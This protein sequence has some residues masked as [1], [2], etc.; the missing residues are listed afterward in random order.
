MPGS[1]RLVAS[2]ALVALGVVIAGGCSSS[3]DE[4]PPLGAPSS[5]AGAGGASAGS[6]GA[7]GGT[8]GTGGTG[9]V[10]SVGV[11]GGS[12]GTS[13]NAGG[14]SG[15]DCGGD[16]YEAM[17]LP[18]DLYVMLD[19]SDSMLEEAG[20]ATKWEAIQ[21]ALTA[22]VADPASNGI[23]MGLQFFPEHDPQVP[24]TCK[25]IAECGSDNLCLR[26]FCQ[27]AG[28]GFFVCDTNADCV[29]DGTNYGP[30]TRLTYCWSSRGAV[31][32]HNDALECGGV[33]GDCIEIGRCSGD[34]SF[35]C[36]DFGAPCTKSDG[37]D[38]G[39]CV[40]D[41]NT[42]CQRTSNCDPRAYEVPAAEI[43]ALP[44]AAAKLTSVIA[45]R[46]PDGRT[47][48]APA[49]EGAVDH[50]RA[51]ATAHPGHSV[52]VVLATDG[53]PTECVAES[54][55]SAI[56]EVVNVAKSGVSGSPSVSTFVIGVFSETDDEEQM[57]GMNLDRIAAAGGTKAAHVIHTGGNVEA[58]FLSALD[59]IR[60]TRLPCDFQIPKPTQGAFDQR[61]VNV[62]YSHDGKTETLYYWPDASACDAA[63]GGWYYDDASAPTTIVAC[64]A[65]C[66]RFQAGSMGA[67]TG[68]QVRI[69]LGCATVVR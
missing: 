13:D 9:G 63:D 2:P 66:A 8:G 19:S 27:N 16:E 1:V 29:Q 54:A 60:G 26:N 62:V 31:G 65:S 55:T 43:A 33:R 68:A 42:Q 37:T 25:L 30:C 14:D 6:G 50:A 23:G 64:P 44:G 28:P 48:T 56:D 24:E 40:H 46:M 38:L 52:A 12:A 59:A 69:Q 36:R 21:G 61:R 53:L 22:F 17:L 49:L 4:R 47:P 10:I 7:S 18:L 51:W 5:A 67:A 35:I 11:T 58:E 20:N 3:R 57:A 34:D 45:A 41:E 15:P 32:C 39:T